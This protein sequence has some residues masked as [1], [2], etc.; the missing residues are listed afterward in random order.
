MTINIELKDGHFL[1]SDTDQFLLVKEC[2]VEKGKKA[3]QTYYKK[4]GHYP[5]PF[6]VLKSVP[7]RLL[8]DSDIACIKDFCDRYNQIYAELKAELFKTDD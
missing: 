8:M 6:A 3:G 5:T 4:I 2:I 1:K 7:A